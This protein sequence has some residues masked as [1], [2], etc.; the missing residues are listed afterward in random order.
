MDFWFIHCHHG[1]ETVWKTLECLSPNSV[2]FCVY[3]KIYMGK[4]NGV[5]FSGRL[6]FSLMITWN[7]IAGGNHD[8]S[9]SNIL[10]H[11][12]NAGKSKAKTI[13]E[14]DWGQSKSIKHIRW[15]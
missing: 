9:W 11:G 4:G 3:A 14:V 7:M 10:Y 8:D 15:C 2:G 13:F 5:L 12:N 6:Q 1:N